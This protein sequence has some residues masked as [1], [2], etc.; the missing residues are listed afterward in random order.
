MRW[1]S[2]LVNLATV[3]AS[4]G[5]TLLALEIGLRFLPVAWAPPVVPPTADNP[6]QRYAAN[7]PF[8][9]SL[10][11]NFRVVT[12]KRTNAQGFVADGDYDA[13][14]TTPLIAVA[15]DSFIEALLV[16]DRESLTGRLQAMLGG[17][18]RAYA[19]AQSGSPLSQYV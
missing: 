12:R 11:W 1:R 2:L 6:I 17:R 14:A 9:W 19:F 3:A 18:G 4:F 8:T 7:T 5:L 15:G 13:A 16:P 10:G